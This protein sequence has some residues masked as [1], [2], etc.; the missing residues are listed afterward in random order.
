MHATRTKEEIEAFLCETCCPIGHLYTL[1][2]ISIVKRVLTMEMP[3]AERLQFLERLDKMPATSEWLTAEMVAVVEPVCDKGNELV[4]E[5]RKLGA[6]KALDVYAEHFS[7]F[8]VLNPSLVAA[9]KQST[10][11]QATVDY[12]R[13]HSSPLTQPATIN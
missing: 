7:T 4:T 6:K 12:A 8:A 10:R 2:M 5:A 3:A 1:V 11:Y 13:K 9:L